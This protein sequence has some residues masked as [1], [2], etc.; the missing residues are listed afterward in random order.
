MNKKEIIKISIIVLLTIIVGIIISVILYKP[1][2]N[3]NEI[4]EEETKKEIQANINYYIDKNKVENMPNNGY[5]YVSSNCDKN[6]N[7]TFDED[8]WIYNITNV[9]QENTE[10]HIYFENN[11]V[12]KTL[13]FDYNGGT[14]TTT[15]KQ[16]QVGFTYGE[17]PTP[18]YENHYFKGWYTS[19]TGG[20]EVN[21]WDKMGNNDVTIYAQY[22]EQKLLIDV[23]KKDIK[24]NDNLII[25][26]NNIRYIGSKPNNYVKVPGYG[27]CRII[28]IFDGN[29]KVVS[30]YPQGQKRQ[31]NSKADKNDHD[32]NNWKLS[33]LYNYLNNDFYNGMDLQFKRVIKKHKWFVGIASD[34]DNASSAYQ[35]EQKEEV[36]NY[37]GLISASEYAY[38]TPEKCWEKTLSNIDSCKSKNWLYR[39]I[40]EWTMT[41]SSES[42][43]YALSIGTRGFI[44]DEEVN[45]NKRYR[46]SFYLNDNIKIKNVS[47]ADGTDSNPYELS[48]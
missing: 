16:V 18:T 4:K 39:G 1:K 40:E 44:L 24:N 30:E 36:E 32:S 11:I 7:I 12:K 13:T 6:A 20:E 8:K 31:W 21:F 45:K 26:G 27:N 17:L 48:N 10:C 47:T 25:E 15:S 3:T 28:G 29:I 35:K 23:L 22:E 14:G 37:L 9:T 2:N 19:K 46:I 42:N 41:P 34:N 33:D 43:K 38:A 5:K